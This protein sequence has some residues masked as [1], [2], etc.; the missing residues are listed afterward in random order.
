MAQETIRLL[1]GR[2]AALYLVARNAE[3]LDAVASDARIRGARAVAAAVADL[4]DV[5]RLPELVDR[6]AAALG[7]ID[8]VLVAQGVL[9][10]SAACEGDAAVTARLLSTNLVGPAVLCQLA[11]L[12]LAEQGSGAVVG[13]SSVAGDRGRA[14]NY[15]YGASKAGLS[16]FLEGLGYR[17]ARRG[18]NVVT[19]KP[20]FV[21]TPMTAD[22]PKNAL[23]APPSAVAAA[24]VRA[25]ERRR[26]VVYVPGFWRLV[27]L[28]I[29]HLPAAVMRR[30]G[31]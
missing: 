5:A 15:A 16:T 10:D 18:V 29:R 30:L 2:G 27:M 14:S 9:A 17:L 23:F 13:I 26:R 28:V 1:A 19:V 31:I 20:G 4:D 22:V 11:A 6:A 7:R 8:L 21:D 12:K 3:K 25:V 24:I